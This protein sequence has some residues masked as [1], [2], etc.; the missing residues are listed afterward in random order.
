MQTGKKDGQLTMHMAIDEK[1]KADL[2]T[3][4]EAYLKAHDKTR[5][6]HLLKGQEP[7]PA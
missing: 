1:L 3:P 5:F 4:E 2:I 7:P 6:K